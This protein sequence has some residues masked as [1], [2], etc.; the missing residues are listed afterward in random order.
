MLEKLD[1]A[2]RQKLLRVLA[3]A[4]WIDG[5]VQDKER[6]FIERLLEK[7]PLGDDERKTALGY[8]DTPPHPAEVDPSKIPPEYREGLVKLV[9]QLVGADDKVEDEE[10]AMVKELEALLLD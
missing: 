1:R 4:A 7:L 9:W 5:E 6:A 10:L 3:A 2:M 8:L